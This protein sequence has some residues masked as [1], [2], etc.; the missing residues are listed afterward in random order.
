MFNFFQK[1][2]LLNNSYKENCLYR[3]VSKINLKCYFLSSN[4][5]LVLA[6]GRPRSK[7]NTVIDYGPWSDRG[8][9]FFDLNPILT[10]PDF[11]PRPEPVETRSK[12]TLF[13]MHIYRGNANRG[14]ATD[15][16]Q[17]RLDFRPRLTV[18]QYFT[19]PGIHKMAFH[20]NVIVVCTVKVRMHRKI[21]K[22]VTFRE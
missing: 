15:R 9:S 1:R 6:H 16:S 5:A 20:I 12:F 19:V 8:K 3:H 17:L 11:K 14:R 22:W 21:E 10:S 4:T 13:E 18:D 7:I 2:F